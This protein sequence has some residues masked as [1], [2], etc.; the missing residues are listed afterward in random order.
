MS[1]PERL[2]E[3]LT[4]ESAIELSH[5]AAYLLSMLTC[6]Y[7]MRG[8]SCV[9]GCQDEPACETGGPWFD[10]V[11]SVLE[12]VA[13]IDAL[14]SQLREQR[15]RH[16]KFMQRIALA[17]MP[18]TGNDALPDEDRLV[19]EVNDLREGLDEQY[20]LVTEYRENNR[21]LHGVIAERDAAERTVREQRKALEQVEDLLLSI[22]PYYTGD[23]EKKS[24][25]LAII[26][27]TDPDV[28]RAVDAALA[29]NTEGE[30]T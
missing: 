8:E 5:D 4:D 20:D 28:M 2:A 14:I 17:T 6:P 26:A 30:G 13:T 27:A 7:A 16:I 1:D 29:P 24:E 25:A 10:E 18:N 23:D 9:T 11:T 21:R 12:R 15:E 19:G 22:C 3:P